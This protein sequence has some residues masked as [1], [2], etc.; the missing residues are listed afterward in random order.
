M[1]VFP[2][3]G[4]ENEISALKWPGHHVGPL[5][6]NPW[7]PAAK[8]SLTCQFALRMFSPLVWVVSSEVLETQR[9]SYAH[10]KKIEIPSGNVT[11]YLK[12]HWTCALRTMSWTH[13]AIYH[14]EKSNSP[15]T[16]I[17]KVPLLLRDYWLVTFLSSWRGFN[18]SYEFV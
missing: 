3:T 16:L 8:C 13:R 18:A 2:E 12:A 14:D 11:S 5:V 4:P 9:S 1:I 7:L 6:C 15:T 17:S 10:E